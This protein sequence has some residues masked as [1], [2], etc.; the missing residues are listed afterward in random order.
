MHLIKCA[1][2][3]LNVNEIKTTPIRFNE[4]V[5]RIE[6]FFSGFPTIMHLEKFPNLTILKVVAQELSQISGLE[7]CLNLVELWICECKITVTDSIVF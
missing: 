6:M 4:N 2:N 7:T 1:A 3:G 5:K